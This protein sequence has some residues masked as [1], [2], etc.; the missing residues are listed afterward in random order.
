[1]SGDTPT[2]GTPPNLA[3]PCFFVGTAGEPCRCPTIR[4]YSH[5]NYPR[6]SFPW[7][8]FAGDWLFPDQHEISLIQ[9][10]LECVYGM[11]HRGHPRRPRY[12]GQSKFFTFIITSCMLLAIT[13]RDL[14][15]ITFANLLDGT[16]EHGKPLAS[17]DSGR[18]SSTYPHAA[19]S[20]AYSMTALRGTLLKHGMDAR[21]IHLAT[22]AINRH[23]S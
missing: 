14:G 5:R 2:R 4:T 10:F 12:K 13:T 16:E 9:R 8:Y 20:C 18:I 7:L 22:S 23:R 1:M 19:G 17:T 6:A 15:E 11:A 21:G 3:N